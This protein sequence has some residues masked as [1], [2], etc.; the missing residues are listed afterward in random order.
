MD[1]SEGC[2]GS[3]YLAEELVQ[4]ARHHSSSAASVVAGDP[5]RASWVHEGSE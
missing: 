5:E 3:Q 4:A 2:C 1:R